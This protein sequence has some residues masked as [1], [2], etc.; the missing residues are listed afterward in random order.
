[1]TGAPQFGGGTTARVGARTR[2]CKC[3]NKVQ[4]L[5]EQEFELFAL[6]FH[7]ETQSGHRINDRCQ[8]RCHCGG[9][10]HVVVGQS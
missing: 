9:V 4:I 1:M 2:L 6:C 8:G 3:S 10:D 7:V 5:L